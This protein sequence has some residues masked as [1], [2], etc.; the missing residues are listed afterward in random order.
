MGTCPPRITNKITLSSG[1]ITLTLPN[2]ANAISYQSITDKLYL[3]LTGFSVTCGALDIKWSLL[4][5]KDSCTL[6]KNPGSLTNTINHVLNGLTLKSGETYKVVAQAYDMRGESGLPVC[7]NALTIDTSRPSGGWIRDG[8]GSKDAQF[9]SSKTISASWGGFKTTH[10]IAKYE[11][12]V[13]IKN[14]PLQSF[15]NVNLAASFTKT[16]AAITDGSKIV[17]KVRA[18]TKAGLYSEISS[19]GVIVDTSR[20]TA[21]K[22]IDGT[23]NDLK[24]ASW[25]TTY[26]A[27]WTSFTDA[28]T[29]IVEYKLG[30]KK[31]DGGLVG[32]GLTSVGSKRGGSISG[33]R[34]TSGIE[35]CAVVE[36]VNAARLSTQATSDC[37]L[38][39]HDAPQPGSVNDGTSP[40]IDYQSGDNIFHANWNGFSDGQKGSGIA[41][42]R[43]KLTDKKSGRVITQW[44]SSGLQTKA[45]ITGL[46]LANGNTYFITVRA[47]DKVG[48]HVEASSDGVFIDTTH[49]V[50]TGSISVQGETAQKNG[51]TVVY[52]KSKESVTVSWPQFVDEHSGM[53]KYQWAIVERRKKS[54]SWKDVP[55]VN[56]ATKAV[57]R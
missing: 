18:F 55:G 47:V 4:K 20:P 36:G 50:Y 53:S 17:T 43:Y 51:E 14:N 49:P 16:F 32:S 30:V 10:G 22:V 29:P 26:N 45:T 41:E 38:I 25:T 44:A 54:A 2:F 19:N 13:Y 21:G 37:L 5:S 56:L 15:T 33:L 24:Y 7:S 34:L 46:N 48:H 31:K 42:Y 1:Q 52:I 27:S 3:K 23:S 9:Q 8:L 6:G 57:L 39:D 28:H 12:A 35:Y 40:D 11:V